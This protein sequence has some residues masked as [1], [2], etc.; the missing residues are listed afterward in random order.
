MEPDGQ[1]II[2]FKII[3]HIL[4]LFYKCNTFKNFGKLYWTYIHYHLGQVTLLPSWSFLLVFVCFQVFSSWECNWREALIKFQIL[5][6][7]AY[8]WA[9]LPFP[10]D[11]CGEVNEHQMLCEFCNFLLP[12]AMFSEQYSKNVFLPSLPILTPSGYPSV[13]FCPVNFNKNNTCILC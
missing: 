2:S 12:T 3:R 1:F 10:M 6:W 7:A 5:W 4:N 8:L 9:L 13:L 11:W